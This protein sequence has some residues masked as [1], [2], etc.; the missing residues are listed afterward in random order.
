M[1]RVELSKERPPVI[2]QCLWRWETRLTTGDLVIIL[3]GGSNL[4][5]GL[6]L[7]L[8]IQNNSPI[9][10]FLDPQFIY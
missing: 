2:Q 5:L 10:P 9:P 6:E 3:E 4:F 7:L 8:N 1:S